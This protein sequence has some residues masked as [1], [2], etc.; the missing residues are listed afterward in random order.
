MQTLKFILSCKHFERPRPI[1]TWTGNERHQEKKK[2]NPK[3]LLPKFMLSVLE[4]FGEIYHD[5]ELCLTCKMKQ[6]HFL[7]KDVKSNQIVFSKINIAKKLDFW[8]SKNRPK[9]GAWSILVLKAFFWSRK[10]SYFYFLKKSKNLTCPGKKYLKKRKLQNKIHKKLSMLSLSL[11][12]CIC[13][14]LSI[15]ISGY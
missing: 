2:Q 9:V 11:C 7:Y 1:L 5:L 15:Y 4:T 14:S 8:N 13:I 3:K 12:M 6:C 10:F